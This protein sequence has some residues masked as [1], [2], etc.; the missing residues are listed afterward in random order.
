MNSSF[1]KITICRKNNS[2]TRVTTA[3]SFF[4]FNGNSAHRKCFQFDTI[5]KTNANH[6]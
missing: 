1:K 4:Y 3:I 6:T 2:D 5:T